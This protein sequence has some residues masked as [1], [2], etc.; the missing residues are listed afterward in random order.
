MVGGE[1]LFKVTSP[2]L[3]A[4]QG[5]DANKPIPLLSWGSGTGESFHLP[6]PV[7]KTSKI[8]PSSEFRS[9]VLV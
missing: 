3:Q 8:H 9:A 7:L 5:L 1:H 2:S 4:I 6:I